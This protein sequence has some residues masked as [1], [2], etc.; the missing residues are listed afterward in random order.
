MR[1]IYSL[2]INRTV[3][4]FNTAIIINCHEN[5]ARNH[6]I[7]E[8]TICKS[9]QKRSAY[10]GSLARSQADLVI[11]RHPHHILSPFDMPPSDASAS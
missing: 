1:K 6:H 3:C 2:S 5:Q 11:N 10:G 9:E 7:K 8:I 4:L